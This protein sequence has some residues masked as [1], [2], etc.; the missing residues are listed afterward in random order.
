[1]SKLMKMLPEQMT[2]GMQITDEQSAVV[3]HQMKR[4]EAIIDSMTQAGTQ[5]SQDHRREPQDADRRR[6][7]FD[8]R[9]GQSA[10]SPV[11]ADEKDDGAD[12]PAADCLAAWQER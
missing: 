4:T 11:R 1:M 10:S 12:E 8:H 3:D 6:F 9:R 5:R 2:G 7:G